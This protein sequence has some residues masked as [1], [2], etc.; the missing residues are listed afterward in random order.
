RD[1][2]LYDKF[3]EAEFAQPNLD[4]HLQ[5][6][7]HDESDLIVVFLCTEYSE[8]EWC[9]LEWR[10]IRDLI[11]KRQS[12]RIMLLRFDN[13]PVEGIFSTDGYAPIDNRTPQEV[14]SLILRRVQ[15]PVSHLDKTD[16][17][18]T[19]ESPADLERFEAQWK[20]AT[21]RFDI[22]NPLKA[23]RYAGYRE[24]AFFPT[25]FQANRYS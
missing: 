20:E 9:G 12:S 25:R 8:K 6:L 16:D 22:V 4:T 3:H 5:H 15:L 14:V 23:K 10:A 18:K 19:A 13:A 11:K 2:V 1:Q 21:L 7:Y 24:S 17:N